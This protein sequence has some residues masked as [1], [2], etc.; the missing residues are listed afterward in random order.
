MLMDASDGGLAKNVLA[1]K[2]FCVV[3]TTL[4][5]SWMAGR[6][7]SCRSQTLAGH[8]Q[9]VRPGRWYVYN[10]AGFATALSALFCESDSEEAYQ[11]VAGPL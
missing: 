1:L 2:S 7:F 6:N 8:Q 3:A 5:N 9:G 4:G 10:R 11:C